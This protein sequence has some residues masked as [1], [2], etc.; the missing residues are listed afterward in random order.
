MSAKYYVGLYPAAP[1]FHYKDEAKEKEFFA[2]VTDN[3]DIAGLEQPCL[4]EFHILGNDFLF[5][6][7]PSEWKI[8]ATAVMYTMGRRSKEAG[9]GLASTDEEGR[10]NAIAHLRHIK[11]QMDLVS[12]KYGHNRFTS[13]E[14]Q[15]APLKGSDDVEGAAHAFMRSL[16]E[17][18]AL[19]F[20]CPVAIE[21][22][23]SMTSNAPHK[24]A[25]LPLETEIAI[26]KEQGF[27]L[28]INWARCVLETPDYNTGAPEKA[29]K[30]CLQE[31]VL[32]GL[33]FS[34]TATGGDWGP[35]EDNH[36]PFAPFPGSRLNVPESLLTVEC[37]ANC[38][39]L[40]KGAHLDFVGA[41][42][43]EC[44]AD[45]PIDHRANIILDCVDA[46][47]LAQGA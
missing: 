15:S 46:L 21:H 41:K 13:L 30:E 10:K 4:D 33:I 44:K 35:Y 27:K 47:N 3:P 26:A 18:K 34:G 7:I 25:F 37:A 9:Y 40:V 11:E 23:D 16:A 12:Q 39:N 31:N 20:P 8:V 36:A 2:K 5:K 32:G 19:D 45:A 29:I 28:C 17:I 6:T 42:L 38:L 24:K 43:L 1:S 14:I 22:C